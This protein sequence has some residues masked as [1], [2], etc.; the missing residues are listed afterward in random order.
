MKPDEFATE[1]RFYNSII[2]DDQVATKNDLVL[3]SCCLSRL[4]NLG[5]R[6]PE[7]Y[8]EHEYEPEL[9][10]EDIKNKLSK[11]FIDFGFYSTADP[12]IEIIGE[13]GALE[14]SDAINDLHDIYADLN[15]A[16]KYFEKGIW[17]NMF[18]YARMMF[19]HWGRHA[20]NLKSYLHKNL[21]DW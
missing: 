13:M 10:T 1:I 12:D 6:L 15:I 9:D 7:L 20:I 19:G 18:W 5:E 17:K 16:L 8:D 14:V 21:H 3:L 11:R 4:L 2:T